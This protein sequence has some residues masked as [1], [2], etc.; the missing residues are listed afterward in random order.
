MGESSVDLRRRRAAGRQGLD[1]CVAEESLGRGDES[2][3]RRQRIDDGDCDEHDL[4]VSGD[5]E[6]AD[7]RR[8]EGSSVRAARSEQG[9]VVDRRHERDEEDGPSDDKRRQQT[10]PNR[11][12]EAEGTHGSQDTA[13]VIAADATVIPL[14]V[15]SCRLFG[16]ALLFSRMKQGR[17]ATVRG[18]GNWQPVTDVTTDTC[19]AGQ[20]NIVRIK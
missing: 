4:V 18:A 7:I 13:F 14:L 1:S 12:G 20:W 16:N 5:A 2:V 19:G 6:R 17:V 10:G 11:G 3:T 9:V 15:R 8:S